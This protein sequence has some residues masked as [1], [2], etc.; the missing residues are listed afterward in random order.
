MLHNV[1]DS[2][3]TGLLPST[4]ISVVATTSTSESEDKSYRNRVAQSSVKCLAII[5]FLVTAAVLA[6]DWFGGISE[7]A[8]PTP[9][10]LPLD[11]D[12]WWEDEEKAADDLPLL[13][14]SN[15]PPDHGYTLEALHDKITALPGLN[16]DLDFNMFSGYLTVSEDNRRSIFYW[17]VE[18]QNDPSSDP[19]VFWTNGGPGCSGLIGFGQ[20]HRPFHFSKDGVI[21]LNPYSW[22]SV[23]NMLYVEIPAGVGFSYSDVP[24]DMNNVGDEETAADNLVV[25]EE[26]FKRFPERLVNE[27]YIS[28]ES[29][30]GHYIPQLAKKIIERMA[31]PGFDIRFKGFLVGNPWVDPFTND[32]AQVRSFFQHGL[33]SLPMMNDWLSKCSE[34]ATYDHNRCPKGISRMRK[35]MKSV[36]PYALDYPI[37]TENKVNLDDAASSHVLHFLNQTATKDQYPRSNDLPRFLPPDVKYLPCAEQHF[38]VWL[39]QKV[40]QEALHVNIDEASKLIRW[41]RIYCTGTKIFF[42]HKF[43]SSESLLPLRRKV[44]CICHCSF[45]REIMIVYAPPHRLKRGFTIWVLIHSLDGIGMSGALSDRLPDL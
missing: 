31:T 36:S 29:Y 44:I 30:G 23:A 19:V 9:D 24:E 14:R 26:F 7:V 2:E 45:S 4:E 22:N 12:L 16:L 33:I 27:F 25:V 38:K 35:N 10:E 5:T 28:S 21:S 20:E 18:S 39:N 37:C 3:T 43:Q 6:P 1:R 32:V 13:G 11:G 17:Y 40:V 41:R 42:N 15:P 34:R 8:E